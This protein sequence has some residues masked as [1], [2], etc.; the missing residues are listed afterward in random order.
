MLRLT[1]VVCCASWLPIPSTNSFRTQNAYKC[2]RACR[3]SIRRFKRANYQLIDQLNFVPNI[4]WGGRYQGPDY[5]RTAR[6]PS[7]Q[8]KTLVSII[9]RT[10]QSDANRE[11]RGLPVEFLR[12]INKLPRDH[13]TFSRTEVPVPDL[14]RKKFGYRVFPIITPRIPLYLWSWTIRMA[15]AAIYHPGSDPHKM[16]SYIKLFDR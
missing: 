8:T 2:H 1:L 15:A 3:T 7:R 16:S 14:G 9:T 11:A 12:D 4:F 13:T 5:R 10:F 6:I